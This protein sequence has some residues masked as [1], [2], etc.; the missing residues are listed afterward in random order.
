M[1]VEQLEL[2]PSKVKVEQQCN[3]ELSSEQPKMMFKEENIDIEQANGK[4]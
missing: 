1:K 3:L 2:E 4:F